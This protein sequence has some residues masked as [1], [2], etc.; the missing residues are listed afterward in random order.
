MTSRE[1]I[2]ATLQASGKGTIDDLERDRW[3][4]CQ[5]DFETSHFLNGFGHADGRFH[6]NVDWAAMIPV[7]FEYEPA[8]ATMPSLPDYWDSID[9]ATPERP[10]RLVTAPAR[11]FLNSTFTET[12]GSIKREGRPTVMIHPEDAVA[13]GIEDGGMV[14]IGNDQGTVTLHAEIFG[15]ANRG[16]LVAESIW[17]NEAHE[18]GIGINALTSA[19][20]VA[21]AGGA[22]FHDTSVWIRPAD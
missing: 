22:A 4:D 20:T 3:I 21:P 6:F 7:G 17:P 2:D 5:P 15:D 1:L 16:T 12:P 13:K 10:F 11:S 8:V 14:R 9:N 19:D 18:D